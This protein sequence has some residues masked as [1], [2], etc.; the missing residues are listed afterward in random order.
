MSKTGGIEQRRLRVITADDDPLARRMVRDALQQEGVVVMAD[1]SDG[2]EAVELARHYRPDVV[3]MDVVMP[4]MDGIKATQQITREVPETRVVML[5]GSDE[6]ELGFVGL[7]AG[8]IGFLTKDVSPEAIPRAIRGV[9]SGEA[10]ISRQLSRKLVEQFQS[11]PE[12]RI[13]VRPVRSPLTPREWE[14]L[15][16]LCEDQ[17]VDDIAEALVLS[18]ETVRSHI[19]NMLRKLGVHSREE[20]VGLADG[21]RDPAGVS[22]DPTVQPQAPDRDPA[23]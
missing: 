10:A 22:V 2:R 18:V 15:D 8:A 13:G 5:T 9:Q 3:L 1:A 12:G 7:R 17:G 23:A 11:R 20:A 4:V 6:D 14:V 19:K 16:L 21:L